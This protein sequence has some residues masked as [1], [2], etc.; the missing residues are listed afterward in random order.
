MNSSLISNSAKCLLALS[1]F[2]L[3]WRSTSPVIVLRVWPV[4][5]GIVTSCTHTPLGIQSEIH[6]CVKMC[7]LKIRCSGFNSRCRQLV[8]SFLIGPVPMPCL[9]VTMHSLHAEIDHILSQTGNIQS[10]QDVLTQ[11]L[12]QVSLHMQSASSRNGRKE[13]RTSWTLQGAYLNEGVEVLHPPFPPGPS[14][15][16]GC[17]TS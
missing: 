1:M 8:A 13:K 7:S 12:V 17:H 11:R 16:L 4:R 10:L 6:A 14:G 9:A 2:L 3:S 15:E 5:M